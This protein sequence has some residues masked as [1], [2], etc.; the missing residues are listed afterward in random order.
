MRVLR[1]GILARQTLGKT[2]AALG[3]VENKGFNLNEVAE[4]ARRWQSG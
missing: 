3:F 2:A 1:Q 4:F